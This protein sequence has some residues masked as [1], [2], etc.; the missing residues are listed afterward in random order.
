M[1]KF[2][3]LATAPIF[4]FMRTEL[5]NF[6]IIGSLDGDMTVITYYQGKNV[7]MEDEYDRKIKE[8]EVALQTPFSW[9]EIK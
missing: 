1:C 9:T 2:L 7:I 3:S 6:S 5:E 8:Y 4:H